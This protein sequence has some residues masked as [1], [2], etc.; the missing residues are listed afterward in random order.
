[1]KAKSCIEKLQDSSKFSEQLAAVNKATQSS[2]KLDFE[3]GEPSKQ[4]LPQKKAAFSDSEDNFICKGISKYGY[5][6]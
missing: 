2:N 6:R 3:K 5:S 1:M 4:V